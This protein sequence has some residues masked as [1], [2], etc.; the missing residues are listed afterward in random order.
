MNEKYKMKVRDKKVLKKIWDS[1]HKYYIRI[2]GYL[3]NQKLINYK[4]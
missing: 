4:L 1:E 2:G 3:H